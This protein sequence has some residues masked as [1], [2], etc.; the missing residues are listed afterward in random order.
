[1]EMGYP[2]F[3]RFF[4]EKYDRNELLRRYNCDPAKQTIAWLPT[5]KELSSVGLFD[6]EI[7]ALTKEYNVIVK[8]HPLMPLSEPHRVE[9]LKQYQF[10]HLITDQ[11]DNLPLYQIADYMLFDYGGPPLAGIYT[12]KKM[13]LLNVPNGEK[14][15][16]T[17][18]FSPDIA[19][20]K[21]ITS[22]NPADYSIRKTI[23]DNTIWQQQKKSRQ[24]YRNKYFAPYYGFSS[25]VAAGILLNIDT[26][27]SNQL[28]TQTTSR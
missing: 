1:M 20:R 21:N 28:G 4:T 15:Q 16:L 13:I 26:L 12:D 18:K 27:L 24:T 11:S 2:R 8:L 7:S 5:W 9:A 6:Q 10:T 25:S 3:D 19:I 17:G 23:S 14:H 22:V